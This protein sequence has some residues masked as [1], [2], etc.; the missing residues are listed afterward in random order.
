MS[1]I[2]LLVI[3]MQVG[4]TAT[5]HDRDGL[6]ERV[7]HVL[8]KARAA[9]VP[10]IYMQHEDAE[11]LVRGSAEWQI[12]PLLETAA[13]ETVLPKQACDSFYDTALDMLLHQHGVT[14]LVITGMDTS[15]CVDTTCRQALSHGYDVTLVA[16]AHSTISDEAM[17]DVPVGAAQRI[18]MHN[19][20]L[21]NLT[22]PHHRIILQTA[23]DI[24]F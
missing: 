21:A 24:R 14:H 12:D 17:P 3:D 1:T 5:A 19:I 23:D 9:D 7:K 15:F 11:E 20:I 4:L 6:V 2:A 13:G 22:H 18:A 16:D 10:V 8:E